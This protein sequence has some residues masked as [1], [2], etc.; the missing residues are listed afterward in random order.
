M[1][2]RLLFPTHLYQ[3][4]HADADFLEEIEAA[5]W[6]V[7]EGD[8]AGHDW[9]EEKGYPGYTSYA[10]LN[11]LPDRAPAFE[12]LADELAAQ[13]LRFAGELHWE[14]PK[15]GLTLD[16][17]WVNV[18]GEGAAHSGHIHPGSVISG[19]YYVAV[20]DGSGDIRFEDPRL[21][22]MM[23]AP[24]LKDEVPEALKRFVYVAPK[25]GDMLMWESWLRHEVMPSRT[26]EARISVSFNFGLAG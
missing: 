5:C 21:A 17:L 7:E 20:P 16:A 9:C 18:L 14:L 25:P 22:M 24:P 11:D 19:T 10:S 26:E 8:Q 6:M 4:R 13:A 3:A 2:T 23:A 1:T 12:T 15:K